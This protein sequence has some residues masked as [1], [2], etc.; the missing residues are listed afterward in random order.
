MDNRTGTQV[1]SRVATLLRLVAAQ[2]AGL[3]TA[4]VVQATGLARATAH[5]LLSALQREGL[6]DQDAAGNWVTGPELF[7]FGAAAAA[8]FDVVDVARPVVR[9]LAARSEESVFLSVRRGSESVCL[10][11]EEG[12]FPVRSHVLHEGIRLPLGVASAGL[13]LLA[14]SPPGEVEEFFR[15]HRDLEQRY[16]GHDETSVRRRAR[17]A[18]RRGYALNPGLLVEGSW[19]MAA[20]VFEAS[21]RATWALS[22]TGIEPRLAGRRQADLGR[23]LLE[24]AHDL[25]LRLAGG[26]R[27]PRTG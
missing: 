8:R 15:H 11:A 13:V 21:G 20:P 16:P 26:G 18:V 23:L 14:F 7:I 25:S 9:S 10:L 12:S 17:Q 6:L 4:Q 5:R 22:I 1:V 27:R 3:G 2:P 19:G 24:H